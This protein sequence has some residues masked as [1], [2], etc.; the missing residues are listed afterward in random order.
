MKKVLIVEDTE[1]AMDIMVRSL[2]KDYLVVKAYDGKEA[3]EKVISEKPDLVLMDISLPILD[4]LTV[5]RMIRH[6]KDMKAVPVLAVSASAMPHNV[7][8][9]LDAG[10]NDF[11]A[12]PVRP[13][14]LRKIVGNYI[15]PPPKA[16][17]PVA[18][19]LT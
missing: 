16:D 15:G 2:E 18:G 10:C 1:D 5:V 6:N 8:D 14:L 12:K 7:K 3:W 9:A 11:I 17:P 13:G 19:N 4:G